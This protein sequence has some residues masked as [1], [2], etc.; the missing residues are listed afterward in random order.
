MTRR[1]EFYFDVGSPSA[2]LAWTQLPALARDAGAQLD[3]CPVLL[4]GIF[5]ATGNVPPA[6]IPAKGRYLAVDLARCA[7]RYG[8]PLIFNDAFPINTLGLMRGAVAAQR[9]GQ[10]DPYLDAIYPAF[11]AHNIDLGN[12]DELD[13]CLRA[14]GLDADFLLR[15]ARED[16]IKGELR[17]RSDAAVQRGLFGIPTMFVG[18]AMFFGQDRLEFVREALN[19]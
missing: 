17:R 6:E 18:P 2:Y 8:V 16:D 15:R 11:W 12:S 4:G 3:Y 14:G 7:R 19:G 13:R 10:L 1:V 9:A 5:K